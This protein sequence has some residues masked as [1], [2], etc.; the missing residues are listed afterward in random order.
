MIKATVSGIPDLK[1]ALAGVVPELRRRVLRNALGA[2]AR[3]VRDDARRRAP[4]LSPTVNAPY[5]TPVLSPTVNAPYR[6]P[7]T[8]RKAI[9]VRTSKESRRAGNVGVFVNVRPA[10][11]GQRGA[12]SKTDPF[13][14][15]FIEFGTKFIQGRQFLQRAADRLPQALQVFINQV[16][17]QIAKLNNRR[18]KGVR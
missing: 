7:G 14:W 6:T 10:K 8:V 2:A 16:G 9:V 13:Y 17:P 3:V 1:A 12:K 4:V 11:R 5:R 18:G 15:R